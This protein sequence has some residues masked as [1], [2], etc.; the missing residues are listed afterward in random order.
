MLHMGGI[1]IISSVV[2]GIIVDKKRPDRCEII[3]SLV[4]I[5]GAIIIFYT[6]R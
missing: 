3:G 2:W 5:G 1:F 6:P 4:A